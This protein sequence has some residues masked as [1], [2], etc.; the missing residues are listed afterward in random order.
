MRQAPA[1]V[2][3]QKICFVVS[4][5][6]TAEAFLTDHI[7]AL[8]ERYDVSLVANADPHSFAHPDLRRAA[9]IFAPIVREISPLADAAAAHRLFRIFRR[10]GFSAVHSLT[11][12]AG[13]LTAIAACAAR[14]PVRIH[15]FTGQV[16]ATRRGAG[17][18]LLRALDRLIAKLDTHI[19]A[20][21]TSQLEFLRA[22]RVLGRQEGAVIAKGS[23]C[24]VDPERFRPD[25][26]ARASARAELRLPTEAIVFLFV[27]RLTRDKGVLDL[28]R[29]FV[30]AA[31]AREDVY[32]AFVGPDEHALSAE[33]LAAAGLYAGR[34]RFTGYSAEPERYMAAADVFCLP[35]YREGFGSVVIEAAAAGLPA[36][37]SRI[38]GIIDAIDEGETGL[39]VEPRD[40]QAL[41][42]AMVFLAEDSLT[43]SRFARAA[44]ERALADFPKAA[45]TAA[46]L[47]FYAR[48]LSAR[49]Y[50]RDPRH[51]SPSRDSRL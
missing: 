15:T 43:R 46:M 32:L 17:R 37:G 45:L 44:R 42:A 47:D 29:A 41:G 6:M 22:E 1:A 20:D 8:A 26:A 18:V 35:S 34:L 48:A 38:Y 19:L 9:R 2:P 21:S 23:V 30:A 11:P 33:I 13:L 3:R 51:D 39:L 36:I 5:P 24:G 4:S 27:G 28:A 40:A 50:A 7:R 31:A 10:G 49:A 25:E 12:K 14:V 16:W